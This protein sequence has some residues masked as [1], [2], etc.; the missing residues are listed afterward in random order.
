MA[1]PPEAPHTD[2]M[3]TNLCF[4]L[5]APLQDLFRRILVLLVLD[6]SPGR[7]G[8]QTLRRDWTTERS[9][10]LR[11]ADILEHLAGFRWIGSR[12]PE[13]EPLDRIIIDIDCKDPADFRSRDD[14]YWRIRRA[15]GEDRIPLV[16]GT[17]TGGGIRVAYRIPPTPYQDLRGKNGHGA[18]AGFL[19]R[20]DLTVRNGSVEV[21]PAHNRLDRQMFGRSMPFLCPDTLR[22]L[23]G[24][25]GRPFTGDRELEDAVR[26]A[27][28][29][30]AREDSEL[31][32]TLLDGGAPPSAPKLV[33]STPRSHPAA[34]DR[35]RKG[36]SLAR[37]QD[38]HIRLLVAGLEAP[39]TR[40]ESEFTVG[41]A[42]CRWPGQFGDLGL[43]ADPTPYEVAHALAL[44]L[45]R[46]HNGYSK[47]WADSVD[48]LGL[49]RAIRWWCSRFLKP[50]AAGG[51]AP[52]DRM[53]RLARSLGGRIPA[54]PH[55]TVEEH[56][57]IQL[58]SL[59]LAGEF[60][61]A[62]DRYQWEVWASHFVCVARSQV[63]R[64]GRSGDGTLAAAQIATEWMAG[65]P[66]GRHSRRYLMLLTRTSTR[67]GSRPPGVEVLWRP[68]SP[69]KRAAAIYRVPSMDFGQARP[70]RPDPQQVRRGI[71]GM[72]HHGRPIRVGE[73]YHAIDRVE[74]GEN[75]ERIYGMGT[76]DR[77]RR[78]AAAAQSGGRVVF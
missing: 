16:Y 67:A 41:A 56:R 77:V 20:N 38:G 9:Q 10:E 15:F 49:A 39:S 28:R 31:S 46:N 4:P 35:L 48:R 75:L 50:G 61:D 65:W 25:R 6:R 36:G 76:A 60:R 69:A 23:I 57:V 27:E 24:D 37:G 59:H 22:P 58:L 45:Y 42:L 71:E 51:E 13:S 73:A 7:W 63:R 54:S 55:L 53:A 1:R 8:Y 70:T 44:W 32:A 47:E 29:W 43:T 26:H 64:G 34:R 52:V 12:L 5:R 40:Y 19:E 14:R 33:S 68:R 62:R 2:T 72:A 74:R 21:Y 3:D 11:D 17:P 78:L 30:Y 18:V 66:Y